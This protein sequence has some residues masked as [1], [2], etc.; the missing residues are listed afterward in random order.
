V[1]NP[2]LTPDPLSSSAEWAHLCYKEATY[3]DYL[4][5]RGFERFGKE[6][7]QR[8]VA[9]GVACLIAALHPDDVVIG[10]GMAKEL[11]SLPDGCRAGDNDNAFLGGFRLWDRVDTTDPGK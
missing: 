10:G 11:Q 4:G 8:H 7:W 5:L 3:E 2:D 1:S 6:Q 9:L